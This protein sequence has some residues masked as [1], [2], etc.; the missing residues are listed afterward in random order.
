MNSV[1][2]VL[3][4]VW[5]LQG[6]QYF[7]NAINDAGVFST[8]NNYFIETAFEFQL[9]ISLV[10]GD[11]N[12]LFIG[13]LTENQFFPNPGRQINFNPWQDTYRF[14]A[15]IRFFGVELGYQHECVHP[16]V[17]SQN[18]VVSRYNS[19]YDRLHIKVSGIF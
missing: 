17:F 5:T 18:Y 15:G 4:M 13:A 12:N 8:N 1:F 2:Q 6:G 7:D 16:V 10:K 11:R 19:S 3:T 14:N 9:P